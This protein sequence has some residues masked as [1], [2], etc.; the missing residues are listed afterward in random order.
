MTKRYIQRRVHR[1]HRIYEQIYDSPCITC[2][3]IHLATGI[4]RNTVPNYIKEM[5]QF[6]IMKGPMIFLKP[7]E[8]YHEY[9]AF[10]TFE[11]PLLAYGLFEKFPRVISRRLCTGKWNLMLISDMSANFS[12]LKGFEKCIHHGVKGATYVSKVVS[13]D[14]ESAMEKVY[15][16]I[17]SP[18]QKSTLYEEV[19]P[20]TWKEQEWTLFNYFKYNLRLPT[21]YAIKTYHIYYKKFS[22]WLFNLSTYACA[23]PT[24]YPC[25][26]DQYLTVDFLFK[27][28]YQKEL[29]DILELLPSTS[30]FFSVGEYLWAELSYLSRKEQNDLFFLILNLQEKGFFTDFCHSNVMSTFQ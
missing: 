14:W 4:S 9:A 27:C 3:D 12:F 15:S 7:A 28:Q 16:A 2:F 30:Y 26:I 22:E 1:Y 17:S 13:L 21:Q 24:F 20:L 23:Y 8:N 25:G 5:Y 29:R 10:L 6:S 19:S 18:K 11:R